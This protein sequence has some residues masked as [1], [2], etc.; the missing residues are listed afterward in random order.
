MDGI[1]AYYAQLKN[2]IKELE[3]ISESDDFKPEAKLHALNI[4]EQLEY[5][6]TITEEM[7][8]EIVASFMAEQSVVN[9]GIGG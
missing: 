1:K 5:K 3:E 8:P 9:L 7:Y 4:I 2:K 6:K